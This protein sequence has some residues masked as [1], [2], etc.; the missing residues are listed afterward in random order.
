M[1]ITALRGRSFCVLQEPRRTRSA[2]ASIT[3][4]WHPTRRVFDLSR[5]EIGRIDTKR[6]LPGLQKSGEVMAAGRC[7]MTDSDV[8]TFIQLYL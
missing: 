3:Q 4:T 5:L 1:M 8:G 2:L 6:N 7:F